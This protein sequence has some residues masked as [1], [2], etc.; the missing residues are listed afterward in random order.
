MRLYDGRRRSENELP[1]IFASLF[2]GQCKN[3]NEMEGGG[4]RR[5]KE[6]EG[7]PFCVC[8]IL[9]DIMYKQQCDIVEVMMK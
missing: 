1:R 7:K 8:Q 3:F 6:E 2:S 5:L 4:P 9:F